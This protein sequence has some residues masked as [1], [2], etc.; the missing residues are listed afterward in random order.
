MWLR[1]V[2]FI[3][4]V[5]IGTAVLTVSLYPPSL[6]ARGPRFTADVVHTDEFRSVVALLDRAIADGWTEVDVQPAP[7]A[8]DLTV[9]RR[10]SLSLTGTIPSVEEVR[11]IEARPH[12]ERIQWWLTYLF[13]DRRYSDYFA[14]RFA[15][16]WVGT[17]G[18]PFIIFRRRRFAL[19]LGDEIH[20]NRP[21]NE[22][23][24]E[25]IT[26]RGLPT[27]RPATNFLTVTGTPEEKNQPDPERL[28]GRVSR[29]FL[30]VRLDCAQCHNHPFESWKQK[31]FQGLA[32]FFGETHMGLV[33]IYDDDKDVYEPEDR[34]TKQK[35]HVEPGVPFQQEL[36]PADGTRRQRLAE[37]V[38]HEKNVYFARAAVNRVWG[39]L[40]GRPMV[41]P[42]DDI[43]TSGKVPPALQI[44]ADDFVAHHYDL[45]RLIR[46]IAGA[47]AYRLDSQAEHEL[48]DVHER[49]WAAF[50]MG[51][52]RPEQLAGAIIQ[53][54][55]LETI[56]Q[57]SHVFVR[58]A[59]LG[60]ENDFVER[61]GDMGD[62]EF[63]SRGGTIPQ[64][65][66]LMNGELVRERTEQALH[67]PARIALL[68]PDDRKAVETAYLGVLTRRPTDEEAKYFEGKLAGK[69]GNERSQGLQDLYWT[70]LN[71][72]EFSWNH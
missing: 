68:A 44:L 17:E 8:D 56:D 40:C 54:S 1:N 59:R 12:D 58:L 41:E 6:P 13:K 57:Q 37:W 21:Y 27:D 51:R 62:D 4:L 31:D 32:A 43:T 69:T 11:A 47:R 38:T 50:P 66:I 49:V 39:L 46:L 65:L 5:C 63:D 9:L 33:G 55:T 72:T 29:A 42:V 30:G 64:R 28:A 45:Q 35:G 52:L 26:A 18:G 10:L 60:N 23:V 70:L 48:T 3:S 22:I 14:E 53:A 19:W 71:S 36:L 34:K 15:R 25:L 16:A 2:L 61:Y 20:R 67:A 7:E 24:R